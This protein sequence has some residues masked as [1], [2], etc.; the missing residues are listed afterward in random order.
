MKK[1]RHAQGSVRFVTMQARGLIALPRDLRARHGLDTP[2]AQVEVLE[3]EDGVIELR[4]HVAVPAEQAWF[5]SARW[6]RLEQAVDGHIA[7]GE[8][9]TFET[10]DDFLSSLER[11]PPGR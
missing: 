4:P 1:T 2:G 3:R 7:R 11:R 8:S 5:W 9:D 10:S 6:Q